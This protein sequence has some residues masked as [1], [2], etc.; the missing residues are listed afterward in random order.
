M[1]PRFPTS[2]VDLLTRDAPHPVG[3]PAALT[4]LAA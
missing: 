3:T 1:F 4:A 2:V